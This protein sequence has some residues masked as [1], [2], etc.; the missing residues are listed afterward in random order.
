[1]SPSMP[2]TSVMWVIRRVPSLSRVCWT[3]RSIAL[4]DLLADRP[5]RQ[6]HAGHQHHGLDAGQRVARGVGVHG[7][8]SSR[9]GRCSSPAAC[10]APRRRGPR[11]RRCGR[12]ASAASCGPGR[13]SV[14]SP[15]PSMLAGRD[16]SRST[17]SWCSCSSAASS[18]VTMRSSVGMNDGQH[19]QRRGLARRR[20]RRRPGCS[21]APARRRRAGRRPAG[22]AC[23]TRSGPRRCTGRRRTCGSSARSRPGPA[24]G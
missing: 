16:S 10:P 23:R 9:R 6:V 8:R 4:D 22:S 11:R 18:M 21:A 12:A 5:H 14:T 24:A 15:L 1:M 20:C 17:W 13:G 2:T 19:V 7:G 3:I